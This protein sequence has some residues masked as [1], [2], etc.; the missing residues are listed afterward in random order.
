VSSGRCA[1][2]QQRLLPRVQQIIQTSPSH[3]RASGFS[4]YWKDTRDTKPGGNIGK[5]LPGFKL[6]LTPAGEAA[7]KQKLSGMPGRPAVFSK[8]TP[9]LTGFTCRPRIHAQHGKAA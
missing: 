1:S 6:P 9:A 7:L 3:R 2:C 5:D 4:G 8:S